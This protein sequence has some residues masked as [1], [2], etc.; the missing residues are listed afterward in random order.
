MLLVNILPGVVDRPRVRRS[1]FH[2]LSHQDA[3]HPGGGGVVNFVDVAVPTSRTDVPRLP[4]IQDALLAYGLS[5]FLDEDG[6]YVTRPPFHPAHSRANSP[7]RD[8][9]CFSLVSFIIHLVLHITH[10]ALERGGQSRRIR[11]AT[12]RYEYISPHLRSRT[13][14][15]T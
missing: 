12:K 9:R 11:P 13:K 15:T 10:R 1:S 7:P 14:S 8:S 2:A 6:R 4:Q 3:S 5:Q